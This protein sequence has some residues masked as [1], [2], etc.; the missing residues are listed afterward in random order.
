MISFDC[1]NSVFPFYTLD[2]DDFELEMYQMQHG[3]VNFDEERLLNL[4]LNPLHCNFHKNLTLSS[5]LDPD[6]N[7]HNEKFNCDF[8]NECSLNNLLLNSSQNTSHYLS[9][10]HLNIRSLNCNLNSLQNLLA[11]INNPFSVI[12]ISETWLQNSLHQLDINGYNFEHNYRSNRTGGG[13]GMY[14]ASTLDYKIRYDLCFENTE[15]AESLFIEIA[16]P[17][18][19]N[20]VMGVIYRPPHQSVAN[21]INWLNILIDKV[22]RDNKKSYI[23][24]DFN[25]DLLNQSFH[26]FTNEFLD[27]MYANMFF[28][29][30]TLP[31]RITSHSATLIDNIFSNDIDQYVFS[32]LILSDISDHLPIFVISNDNEPLTDE[33]SYTVFRDKSETNKNEFRNRLHDINWYDLENI[34][35]PK[36]AYSSFLNK[37]TNLYNSCF[38]LKKVEKKRSTV[39]KPWLSNGLLKSIRKKN[40]LYKRYLNSPTADNTDRYKRFKNKLNHLLRIAKRH[41]YEDLI[42]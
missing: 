20:Y 13:V 29:A 3:R 33:A 11:R 4:K 15:I 12:G 38:S 6:S 5:N 1:P 18:G 9:F 7:F 19:K 32:G 21:F 41:Y 2:D 16:N 35:E 39:F 30:I 17:K 26:Q 31:T 37:F 34:H 25:L 8:F 40:Q 10:M 22:S 36:K 27:I 14:I 24:G 42:E 28:P 23:M